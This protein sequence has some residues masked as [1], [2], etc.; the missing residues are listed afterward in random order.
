LYPEN[1]TVKINAPIVAVRDISLEAV[2]PR[3]VAIKPRAFRRAVSKKPRNTRIAT[4]RDR[5]IRQQGVGEWG[6]NDLSLTGLQAAG[7]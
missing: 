2:P 3:R 6:N 5:A 1:A 4:W 7:R